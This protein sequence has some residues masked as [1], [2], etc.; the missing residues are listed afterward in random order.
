MV[1]MGCGLTWKLLYILTIKEPTAD[2]GSGDWFQY[3]ASV[4]K[5]R[6]ISVDL[7]MVTSVGFWV[8]ETAVTIN[9]NAI[10]VTHADSSSI[11][12]VTNV[13]DEGAI[14]NLFG[15]TWRRAVEIS[16]PQRPKYIFIYIIQYMY[17]VINNRCPI[18]IY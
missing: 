2:N 13:N 9:Q 11:D 3:I 7:S 12:P 16:M 4:I 8:Y 17:R 6:Q 1:F 18:F 5:L 15:T 14:I 10:N